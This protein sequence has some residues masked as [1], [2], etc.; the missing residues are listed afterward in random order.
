MVMVVLLAAHTLVT[1]SSCHGMFLTHGLGVRG[2]SLRNGSPL[3]WLVPLILQ[4][5]ACDDPLC[6]AFPRALAPG[7]RRL[8]LQQGPG[9]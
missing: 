7:L 8:P 2:F 6:T 4:L 1:P 3:L 9:T 5:L